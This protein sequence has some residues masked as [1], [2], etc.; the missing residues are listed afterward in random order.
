MNQHTIFVSV[1][2]LAL[3]LPPFA[4]ADNPYTASG[5]GTPYTATACRNDLVLGLGGCESF[6]SHATLSGNFIACVPEDQTLAWFTCYV[7]WTLALTSS[8]ASTGCL[9]GESSVNDYLLGC[10]DVLGVPY[11]DSDTKNVTYPHLPADRTTEEKEWVRA[12]VDIGAPGLES[13]TDAHDVSYFITIQTANSASPLSGI[14][15]QAI[16]FVE[17][18]LGHPPP[19]AGPGVGVKVAVATQLNVQTAR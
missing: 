11:E 6:A 2:I 9:S 12:C 5:A 4:A 13:C 3:L 7:E 18:V 15:Q 16:A 19:H 1:V 8:G 14:V 17:D 10:A